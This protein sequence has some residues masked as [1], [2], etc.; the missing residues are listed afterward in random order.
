MY[1]IL[2]QACLAVLF[3]FGQ[4]L[5]A[6]LPATA[7]PGG[8]GYAI[9]VIPFYGPEKIWMLYAP[10]V[11]YLR[12]QTGKPWELK[13][14][15]A[16]EA[17]LAA[18]CGGEVAFALL[19]P[20]PLG[21]AIEQC[22]A[23]PVLVALGK[24]G[25]PDYHSVVVTADPAIDALDNLRGK[26]F[27]FFKGSTAAHIL[28]RKILRDAGLQ[29]DDFIPVF[30]ES[31][32]HILNALLTLEV[33]AGGMKDSLYR[34]FRDAPLRVLETSGPLPNFAFAA[35]PALPEETKKL[36]ADTLLGLHP[37]TDEALRKRMEEWDDEIK[38]GFIPPPA[39]FRQE[40]LD[41]Q[42]LT[43]DILREVR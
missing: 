38:N 1:R 23:A 9:T 39:N 13:L 11:H 31:Q 34:K 43:K 8:S 27:A 24:D 18:L 33:S 37:G 30:Y 35:A 40:V 26:R 25:K 7:P 15:A 21:R 12:E 6:D 29:P 2:L 16:H 22:G 17:L 42:A 28:P 5:A 41:L 20:V 32:D 19:G 3:A 14:F 10:F 36:F 4:G